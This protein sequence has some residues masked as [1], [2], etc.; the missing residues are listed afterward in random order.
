[1][2]PY[3]LILVSLS[4]LGFSSCAINE[5]ENRLINEQSS[6]YDF[7]L[8]KFENAEIFNCSCEQHKKYSFEGLRK[9]NG[10]YAF[11]ETYLEV[12]PVTISTFNIKF[13]KVNLVDLITYEFE[14][15]EDLLKLKEFI[16]DLSYR[17]EM[18]NA[19]HQFHEADDKVYLYYFG[20]P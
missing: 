16:P 17:Y 13:G 14:S 10:K 7:I 6:Q 12:G 9:S 18:N 11:I 20:A 1:M 19:D 15:A 5:C 4:L 8:E 3:Y 2:K